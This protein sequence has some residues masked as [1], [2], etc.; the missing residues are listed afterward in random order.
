MPQARQHPQPAQRA[1]DGFTLLEMLVSVAVLAT[2]AALTIPSMVAFVRSARA[3]QL[4]GALVATLRQGRNEAM[5]RNI[6]VLVC[7]NDGTNNCANSTDWGVRGWLVCYA[8]SST[9]TCDS[10]TPTLP[11]PI[12]IEV[13]QATTSALVA[14][15]SNAIRFTPYGAQGSG[16]NVVLTITGTWANPVQLKVTVYPSG[17]IIGTRMSAQSTHT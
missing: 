17:Q 14:G 6:G 3:N 11:N 2:L 13:P 12:M 10:S 7:A 1:A 15:P 8:A 9:T 16:N 4:S 5:K